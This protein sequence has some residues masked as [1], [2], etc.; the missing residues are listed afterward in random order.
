MK[1]GGTDTS[2]HNT[3]HKNLQVCGPLHE[4]QPF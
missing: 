4:N 2:T 3:I 1:G